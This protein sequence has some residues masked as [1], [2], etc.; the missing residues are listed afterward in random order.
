MENNENPQHRKFRRLLFLAWATVPMTKAGYLFIGLLAVKKYSDEYLPLNFLFLGL[1]F[2]CC[3]ASYLFY[4]KIFSNPKM[5]EN[6]VVVWFASNTMQNGVP[7]VGML[8]FTLLLIGLGMAE[9]AAT[10]GLV[11]FLMTSNLQFFLIMLAMSLLTW[12]AESPRNRETST[13]EKYK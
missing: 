9:T 6:K 3:M 7:S 12:A 1:G 13:R 11:G 5:Y 8:R 10:F 4:K 2:L